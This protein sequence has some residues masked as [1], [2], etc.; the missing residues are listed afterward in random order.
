MLFMVST[1]DRVHADTEDLEIM[2]G[3]DS[4]H[5]GS[6]MSIELHQGGSLVSSS[7]V[8]WTIS[9]NQSSETCIRST[10][11]PI[12]GVQ[13]MLFAALDESA[14]ELILRA[15]LNED[16]S[17]FAEIA[18][19]VLAPLYVDRIELSGDKDAVYID[20][21]MTVSD[22]Y[23]QFRASL[24]QLFP[25]PHEAAEIR[26][27]SLAR[28]ADEYKGQKPTLEKLHYPGDSY[29]SFVQEDGDYYFMIVMDRNLAADGRYYF[30]PDGVTV[31]YNGMTVPDYEVCPL[32]GDSVAP[33]YSSYMGSLL[34]FIKAQ[35]TVYNGSVRVIPYGID[36]SDFDLD[37][38]VI[39]TACEAPVR[40]GY[41]SE[42]GYVALNAES[43]S[44]GSYSFKVPE[45]ADNVVLVVKGDATGDGAANLGDAARIKAAF[46]RKLTLSEVE[47]FAADVNGDGSVNLG[48]AAQVTAAFRKK[49][50]I[51]W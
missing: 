15:A 44:D 51:V 25:E 3:R 13:C 10:N 18:V 20:D 22:A 4:I 36:F 49:Y 16:P 30:D 48:D 9:G 39:T 17:K 38:D 31:L 40:A 32:S 37:G 35:M 50:T 28:M 33:M 14:E 11:H 24:V 5:A 45:G 46:R 34:I 42:D 12:Y 7:L 1:V 43:G 29:D 23:L 2:L 21:T 19:P 41:L 6:S 27:V 47:L 26:L 8:T